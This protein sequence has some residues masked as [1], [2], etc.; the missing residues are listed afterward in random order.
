M[1]HTITATRRCYDKSLSAAAAAG[2]GA[3][4]YI[5]L[6]STATS[7]C[8]KFTLTDAESM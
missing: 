8:D 6:Y 7:S 1:L 2:C 5:T 3:T 4:A